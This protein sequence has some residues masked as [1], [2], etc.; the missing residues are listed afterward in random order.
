M[1]QAIQDLLPKTIIAER[2]CAL[3]MVGVIAILEFAYGRA[4]I[5]GAIS[6]LTFA[7]DPIGGIFT[8][9]FLLLTLWLFYRII[10]LTFTSNAPVRLITI[11][12]IAVAMFAEFSYL[13]SIGRFTRYTDI[14]YAVGTNTSQKLDTIAAFASFAWLPGM[15]MIVA[16]SAY[17]FFTQNPTAARKTVILDVAGLSVAYVGLFFLSPLFGGQMLYSSSF[18]AFAQTSVNYAIAGPVAI[19]APPKREPIA[20]VATSNDRPANNVI[21]IFDESV[22]GR[23][24]SLNGYSRPTTPFLVE[25][26][27]SGRLLNFGVASSNYTSSQPSFDSFIVGASEEMLEGRTPDKLS[28]MPTIF[29]YARSMNYR[30]W[31][32][33][34]QMNGYWAG[35]EDDKQ[36]IDEILTLTDLDPGRIED[37]QRNNGID[38][39]DENKHVGLKQWDIDLRLAE[40]IRTIFE[41]SS[42]NF[43]F[44]YKRGIHFPYEKN[45]PAEKTEWK[46]I[47]H[48]T[49][50]WETPPAEARDAVINSYD[51]ALL[52]GLDQFFRKLGVG[53]DLPNG[54]VIVYTSD[55]G[56]T[57]G[58]GGRAGH[59][60]DTVDEAS[61]PLF[62]IGSSQRKQPSTPKT[63]H[64]NI[65][66]ALLDVMRFPQ[67][68]RPQPYAP[69]VLELHE[70]SAPRYYRSGD[71]QRHLFDN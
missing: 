33:D 38:L 71:G 18:D 45:Y 2:L 36:Y 23:H 43:V 31:Y 32:L 13:R 35:I 62:I 41:T 26:E 15:T 12:V 53:R 47:Y 57:F 27:A 25:L 70:D 46:P 51:N 9:G 1:L 50:Q 11:G 44:V 37:Y 5:F 49:S 65:F 55:H 10:L 34:G 24:L 16:I 54:T 29:Q 59:G 17:F 56:E 61:V 64:S 69:S 39:T 52:F 22:N 28:A 68:R 6:Q 42:G 8:A 63:Q 40:K 21:L 14:T 67:E 48:F 4:G 7:D 60:G 58:S 3:L 19:A 66:A 30:T 20:K